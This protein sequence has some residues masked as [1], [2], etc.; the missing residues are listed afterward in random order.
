MGESSQ[1]DGC[2]LGPG[3]SGFIFTIG[4]RG[5]RIASVAAEPLRSDRDRSEAGVDEG[6]GGLRGRGGTLLFH[7][8]LYSCVPTC[9]GRRDCIPE[10]AGAS[11]R[12]DLLLKVCGE[13]P[14]FFEC[15]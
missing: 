5:S 12:E 6:T 3:G 14:F 11:A 10:S 13:H 1:G 7:V 9:A 4:T 8:T 2:L 15:S